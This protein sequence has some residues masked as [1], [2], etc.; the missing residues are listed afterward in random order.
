MLIATLAC[1]AFAGWLSREGSPLAI[2]YLGQVQQNIVYFGK[3]YKEVTNKYIDVVDPHKLMN[4]GIDAMLAAV[5][6]YT[7]VIEGEE[8]TQLQILTTGRYGGLGMVIGVR[9]HWPTI[10]EPPYDDTP[11]ARAGCREGD[12]IVLVDGVSTEEMS[13]DEV[14]NLMR[15][16]IGTAVNI[17][18]ARDGLDKA[19]EF[20][21]VRAEI[22]VKD[23]VF[24][25]IVADSIGYIKLSR[26][27]KNAI[28]EMRQS[29][30]SLKN[31]GMTAGLII[32]LRNN[33]GGLLE[34][35]V[36]IA[37]I[38][39]PKGDFIVSTKGR[40]PDTVQRYYSEN[41]PLLPKQPLILLVNENSAS[42]S[43][44]MAGAM[45]D[46]DRGVIIGQTTYGKG[47]VQSII[48]IDHNA[49]LKL[50]TAK[51]YL[52]S[53]R[54][55]Q[56]E[57]RSK[58]EKEK[59]LLLSSETEART[60]DSLKVFS[61]AIGREVHGRGGISPDVA[62]TIDSLNNF[63]KSL[64]RQS[65]MFTYAVNFTNT[66]IKTDSFYSATP[67]IVDDF[68]IFLTERQFNYESESQ[69]EFKELKS[70]LE[71]EGN[72]QRLQSQLAN[73]ESELNQSFD[74][75]FGKNRTFI[76][77]QLDLELATKQGGSSAKVK[78]SF[79]ND[80]EFKT[81]LHLLQN[82]PQF[83]AILQPENKI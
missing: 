57:R 82:P 35:A 79:K 23:V 29:V 50:T 83:T 15:G 81:A 58:K 36:G 43:E 37:D 67:E 55:I 14:A 69:K 63:Q 59:V 53:G 46:L 51:Y 77:E 16:E 42:A 73:L 7:I 75:E 12:R 28:R 24:A 44:I 20:K 25:D 62:L 54:L 61:T 13:V 48:D 9:D 47:L 18:I 3:V 66:H 49:Q 78:A 70:A 60:A 45:Q 11:A 74:V 17:K 26:F 32:D 64:L 40:T 52:P 80:M 1:I 34:S 76:E 10:M 72:L 6:D 31:K 30:L 2:D 22:I 4:I 33:P 56:R 8:N 27:S 21:L 19:L 71:K 65:M 68:K 5:D 41:E 39:L 38:F